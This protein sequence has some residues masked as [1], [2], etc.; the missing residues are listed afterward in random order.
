MSA[1]ALRDASTRARRPSALAQAVADSAA[2][3]AYLENLWAHGHP[4]P[5]DAAAEP[6]IDDDPADTYTPESSPPS[7]PSRPPNKQRSAKTS[8]EYRLLF[9]SIMAIEPL[10]DAYYQQ[11][12]FDLKEASV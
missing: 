11:L 4:H 6:R 10:P 1:S 8:I 3:V 2:S 12:P 7:S 5:A 9:E